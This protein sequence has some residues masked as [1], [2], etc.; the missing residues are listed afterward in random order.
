MSWISQLAL[1]CTGRLFHIL[2]SYTENDLSAKVELWVLGTTKREQEVDVFVEILIVACLWFIQG[3]VYGTLYTWN[4]KCPYN[5]HSTTNTRAI[6]NTAKKRSKIDCSVMTLGK[7]WLIT[8]SWHR[9]TVLFSG[10]GVCTAYGD[11]HYSSFDNKK[12]DF[13]GR[14]RYILAESAKKST[15]P[16]F[17]VVVK[18]FSPSFNSR[19]TFTDEV[20]VHV[21][22][23]VSQISPSCYS[24]KALFLYLS[25]NESFC[26]KEK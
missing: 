22:G 8:M 15:L 23:L 21:S 12:F 13:Q 9:Y 25:N 11:P 18:H 14:C 10:I 17:K 24:N 20:T 5:T 7:Y 6:I 1:I 26:T 3:L 19:V 16:G 4:V 2:G